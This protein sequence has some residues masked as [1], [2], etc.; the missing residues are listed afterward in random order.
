MRLFAVSFFLVMSICL[1]GCLESVIPND[2]SEGKVVEFGKYVQEPGGSPRPLKWKV[3]KVM[4]GNALLFSEYG[5]CDRPY[6]SRNVYV[7][8]ETCE[9]RAWLNGEFLK[10]A[11][12]DIERLKIMGV[13]LQNGKNPY[14]GVPGGK[15]TDDF[16]FCLSI[17]EVNSLFLNPDSLRRK[18]TPYVKSKGVLTGG[19]DYCSFWLRSP[20]RQACNAAY[21]YFDGEIDSFGDGVNSK[22]RAVCPA[23]WVKVK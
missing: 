12:T 3:L 18:A 13:H 7:S 5:I 16:I 2:F 4:D 21:V 15:D 6:N 22:N 19:D 11:F 10:T 23:V 8:W 17:S 9:L 1:C 14:Y 20:G